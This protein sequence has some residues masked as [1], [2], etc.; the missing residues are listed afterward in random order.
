MSTVSKNNIIQAP[1]NE[2]TLLK[3][4][5]HYNMDTEK[6]RIHYEK[7]GESVNLAKSTTAFK[8]FYKALKKMSNTVDLEWFIE[9][10]SRVR[11]LGSFENIQEADDLIKDFA[12]LK[13]IAPQFV[14]LGRGVV[15]QRS[16]YI[17]SWFKRN[18][19]LWDHKKVSDFNSFIDTEL[20][21]KNNT[22]S[23]IQTLTNLH[24]ATKGQISFANGSLVNECGYSFM[25]GMNIEQFAFT[26]KELNHLFFDCET[27]RRPFSK[28]RSLCHIF[29][30]QID[31]LNKLKLIEHRLDSLMVRE[32]SKEDLSGERIEGTATIKDTDSGD[33]WK[34]FIKVELH[35]RLEI[36]ESKI[37]NKVTV[38][39]QRGDLTEC[40]AFC[41]LLFDYK[42]FNEGATKR[43][44]V[45]GFSLAKYGIDITIQLKSAAKK[46]REKHKILLKKHFI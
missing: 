46:G 8:I 11:L 42:Y 13:M 30:D 29:S 9:N 24:E 37:A 10:L 6:E 4:I 39:R 27:L 26:K 17:E 20:R 1:F 16:I 40:A 2:E 21:Y 14:K 19:F 12:V 33:K 44:T 15:L 45:N 23:K 35:D 18:T 28:Y 3:F 36:I 22:E 25:H 34:R 32:K 38:W 5:D 41:Q 31:N 7:T 43:I